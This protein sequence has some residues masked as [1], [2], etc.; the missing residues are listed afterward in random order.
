MEVFHP[1]VLCSLFAKIEL[2]ASWLASPG[3]NGVHYCVRLEQSLKKVIFDFM[4]LKKRTKA[5][6]CGRVGFLN[7]I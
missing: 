6:G 5:F 4:L 7:G 1:I 2:E 3:T